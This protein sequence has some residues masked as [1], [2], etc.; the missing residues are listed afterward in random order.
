MRTFLLLLLAAAFAVLGGCASS[1]APTNDA[2]V[3]N[4]CAVCPTLERPTI[5]G[6]C[7]EGSRCLYQASCGGVDTFLCA[8]GAWALAGSTCSES[9][10]VNDAG[11]ELEAAVDATDTAPPPDTDAE[12]GAPAGA[13]CPPETPADGAPCDLPAGKWC[14]YPLPCGTLAHCVAGAWSAP[15]CGP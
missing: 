14:A 8:S 7:I 9:R 5:G 12:T 4:A 1:A 15:P 10:R 6:A 13:E 11:A 3:A 2:P